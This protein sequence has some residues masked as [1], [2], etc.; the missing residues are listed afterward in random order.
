MRRRLSLRRRLSTATRWPVGVGLTSWRYL[1]RTVP[2]HRTEEEGNPEAD[3]P[4]ALPAGIEL[5]D[6]QHPDDGFGPS[7]IAVTERASGR[8]S[9][10][11]RR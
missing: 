9:S 5:E 4:P 1:W 3:Y 7:S 11:P 6:V 10:R 8:R 2:L